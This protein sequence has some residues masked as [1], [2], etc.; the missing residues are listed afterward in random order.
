MDLIEKYLGE[1]DE[2]VARFDKKKKKLTLYTST[3][4]TATIKCDNME[5]ARA[6]IKRS[7]IEQG[8]VTSL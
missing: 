2:R 6:I 7:G 4:S 5:S 8:L 1:R 3:N